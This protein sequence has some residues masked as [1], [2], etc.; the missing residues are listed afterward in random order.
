MAVTRSGIEPDSGG[1]TSTPPEPKSPS[2]ASRSCQSLYPG[3]GVKKLSTLSRFGDSFTTLSERFLA[4]LYVVALGSEFPVA[5]KIS[6][7]ES[8]AS[9]YPDIQIDV[10]KKLSGDVASVLFK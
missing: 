6:P 4:V 1:N 5:K 2:S 10:R 3:G 7:A 9:P 8:A